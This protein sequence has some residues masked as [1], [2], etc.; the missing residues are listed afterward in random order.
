MGDPVTGIKLSPNQHKIIKNIVEIQHAS[1][2]RLYEK[3]GSIKT[4]YPDFE[5]TD[6]ELID[7]LNE[8]YLQFQELKENPGII[9]RMPE[10]H[11]STFRHILVNLKGDFTKE[12]I[13]DMKNLWQTLFQILD[14]HEGRSSLN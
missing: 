6:E 2:L 3:A 13:L 10:K 4:Y 1:L 5:A 14:T 9:W 7:Y 11:L 12:D 8:A